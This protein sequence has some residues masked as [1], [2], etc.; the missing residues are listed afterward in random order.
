MANPLKD[1]G[2][3][4]QKNLQRLQTDMPRIVGKT[5]VDHYQENFDKEGFVDN[6]VN[7]WPDV[8]RRDPS[9]PWYGFEYRGERA[10][11]KLKKK[12]KGQKGYTNGGKNRTNFSQ[13]ATQRKVLNGSTHELRR[14][15]RYV[16]RQ[17]GVEILNDKPYAAI[18]NEG[19]TIR[20][21]GRGSA[22]LPARQFVGESI[23]LDEKIEKETDR[24][25]DQL[26]NT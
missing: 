11:N 10:T 16:P 6:G 19:G 9:S 20:V 23:E 4:I 3:N 14:A 15:L 7:K 1:I 12:G 18:H 24:K 21:F 13:A 2:D 17:N 26:F 8:K 22:T 5:A 25:L